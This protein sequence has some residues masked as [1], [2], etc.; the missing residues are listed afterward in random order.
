MFSKLA[1]IEI[2]EPTVKK[3]NITKLKFPIGGA[4]I[5]VEIGGNYCEIPWQDVLLSVRGNLDLITEK[6]EDGAAK[7][8]SSASSKLVAEI[9]NS[10]II[11]IPSVWNWAIPNGRKVTKLTI[12]LKTFWLIYQS[13]SEQ[14]GPV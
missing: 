6:S 2:N 4:F 5:P 7:I 12:E 10:N 1:A 8:D 3:N 11:E 13:K 9:F 14:L